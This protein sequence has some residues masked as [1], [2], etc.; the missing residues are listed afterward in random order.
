MRFCFHHPK[1]YKYLVAWSDTLTKKNNGRSIIFC[2]EH[3]TDGDLNY[4]K[5]K[6]FKIPSLSNIGKDVILQ[7]L[8]IRITC[9]Y[10]TE[11][12][13]YSCKT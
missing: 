9:F 5:Q 4:K 11:A 7:L 1:N 6:N 12:I 13:Q 8:G 3:S 10:K 2:G